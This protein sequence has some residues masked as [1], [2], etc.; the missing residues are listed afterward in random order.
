M[1]N[2]LITDLKMNNITTKGT[3]LT[4]DFFITIYFNVTFK[5]Y[6]D[7]GFIVQIVHFLLHRHLQIDHHRCN[8]QK[9]FSRHY[10]NYR[11]F[12]LEKCCSE[13][14]SLRG[15]YVTIVVNNNNNFFYTIKCTR[16]LISNNM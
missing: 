2:K 11:I 6:K 15:K 1:N 3:V 8:H 13:S 12:F 14:N 9:W 10:K 4:S 7:Q 16:W 5:K